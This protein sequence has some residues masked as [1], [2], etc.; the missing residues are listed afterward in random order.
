MLVFLVH[1]ILA[2]IFK[3]VV[4]FIPTLFFILY[5]KKGIE[6]SDFETYANSLTLYADHNFLIYFALVAITYAYYT[7]DRIKDFETN[8]AILRTELSD[9][10]LKSLKSHLQPHFLFNTLNSIFTLIDH[11]KDK[12]KEMIVDL[13]DVLREIVVKNRNNKIELQE[14]LSIID[15]YLNILK[16]RF[17]NQ[18][19]IKKSISPN[20]ELAL[21]PTLAIQQ[22][23]EN[24]VKHGY[25]KNHK[26][27]TLELDIS[28]KNNH[29][30]I[31]ISNNG[32]LL[33]KE[34]QTLLKKGN[35]LN[36]LNERLIVL[37]NNDFLFE[38]SNDLQNNKVLSRLEIP[39]ELSISTL[40]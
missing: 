2:F 33:D 6:W 20:L 7:F 40:T 3:P 1:F 22:L 17:E 36:N 37:Y 12:S 4:F 31:E 11:D 9:A 28:K 34:F 15:K 10:K 19:K 25:S 26:E 21:I 24:A 38:L 5:R 35:G 27:L 23:I 30:T 32:K 39:F 8:Q 18:L 14:E 29:L 13:S 16:I